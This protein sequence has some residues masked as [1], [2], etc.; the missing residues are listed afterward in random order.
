[1]EKIFY[2]TKLKK[3][4]MAILI[5]M[6]VFNFIIPIAYAAVTSFDPKQF[7]N[8]EIPKNADEIYDYDEY[9]ISPELKKTMINNYRK[10]MGIDPDLMSNPFY[11]KQVNDTLDAYGVAIDT[12]NSE[13]SN[14][15]AE[16]KSLAEALKISSETAADRGDGRLEEMGH[17]VLDEEGGAE[18]ADLG[19]ILL[20]PVFYLINFVADA[21]INL[22]G[23]V[24]MPE[25][26]I[27]LGIGVLTVTAPDMGYTSTV[28]QNVDTSSFIPTNI[29]GALFDGGS[30]K[31]Q[32]PNLPY[33]P[34]AIF[35]GTVELLSIDFISGNVMNDSGEMVQNTNSGWNNIRKLISQWYQVLRMIAIIGLLS[36]L[37]YTGIKIII[38]A[39]A[40]D[41]A[42]YKEWI[43]D[44]LMGAAILFAMHIIMAFIIAVTNEFSVLMTNAFQGIHVVP[45]QGGSAFDTNLMGLVRFMVQSENFYIKVG[46]E[47]MYIALIWY[48]IKFTFTYLKRV[49]NMAFLTLIAP[50]VALTYPIDKINDGRAQGFDMWLKEY[51][52]NALLQP[53]H[54]ILY[55][56]LVGSAVGIAASNPLYGIVVLA[57]MTEAEKLL[58]KIFGFDKAGG[59]TVGSMTGAFA[60]GAIASNIG[61]IAKLAGGKGGSGNADKEKSLY[62]NPKPTAKDSGDDLFDF[63]NEEVAAIGGA[64]ASNAYQNSQN[65][66]EDAEKEQ[67][68]DG[69]I[70]KAEL[71]AAQKALLGIQEPKKQKEEQKDNDANKSDNEKSSK[72]KSKIAKGMG[73][74]GK[75]LLKP[76]CDLDHGAAYNGKRLTRKVGKA[77]L[78][79]GLGIGA[80]AVQAGISITDGKYNPA[81]GFAA[82]A[83]GYAGAG[84]IFNGAE[85]L[86]NTYQ[87]GTLSDIPEDR[88]KE[89]MKRAQEKWAERDDVIQHNKNKYKAEDREAVTEIQQKLL[90]QGVTDIKEMDNCIKYIKANNNKSVQNVTPDMVRKARVMHD[91]TGDSSVQKV[92]Y[93]PSKRKDYINSVAKNDKERRILENKFDEAIKYNSIVNN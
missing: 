26:N 56:V 16:G 47:V 76:V 36:V 12:F 62:D 52:F 78:G 75:K 84:T 20:S 28:I 88:K 63:Q 7:F 9:L 83:A 74:V 10:S 45:S 21:V 82:L 49:L 54:A 71:T 64:S 58:K 55:Y 89:I 24:M 11:A 66:V 80:A 68:A 18:I 48:T 22:V 8:G 40:K 70:S 42:K 4:I 3:I 69:Q 41:K 72:E 38:S 15:Q 19:G 14:A 5:F 33:T 31:F 85:G 73:N 25:E 27:D 60:A 59:G 79:T 67:L 23:S 43:M 39:N 34:E 17:E 61:K 91:F 57:F 50:I 6:L 32:Y 2:N 35:S 86:Y 46:Y 13:L 92:M 77:V 93:D 1:M 81:E 65:P 30:I 29:M 44:W 53:M 87:E 37:I 90:A 51:I